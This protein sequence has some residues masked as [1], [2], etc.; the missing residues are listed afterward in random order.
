MAEKEQTAISKRALLARLATGGWKGSTVD[1]DVTEEV[2]ENHNAGEGHGRYVKNLLAPEASTAV[3]AIRKA[4]REYHIRH[5]LPWQDTW[6]LLPVDKYDAYKRQ[7]A[8][9]EEKM[10]AAR[11][12]LA[13]QLPHWKEEARERLGTAFVEEDYPTPEQLAA[14]WTID[15]E[16]AQVPDAKHF[17]AD[18]AADERA[19]ITENIQ[20][21]LEARVAGAVTNLYHR[22]AGV[23]EWIEK[24]LDKELFST[25][26][27]KKVADICDLV[28]Q[29]NITNDPGL[30]A[31]VETLR[32]A[33]AGT[34][35]K[36][37]RP[38]AKGYDGGKRQVVSD[39]V[40]ALRERMG[41]YLPAKEGADG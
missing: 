9:Y 36:E 17:I 2:R 10:V 6:R 14:C 4:V 7:I 19:E 20:R 16:Y 11:R 3:R 18:V 21:Q 33:F 35:P 32:A 12:D 5:T 26:L 15:V 38:K 29:L 1:K 8:I 31:V 13:E 40:T 39:A 25:A 24:A 37:L 27:H 41:G 30:D 23:I 28:P 34:D 22:I